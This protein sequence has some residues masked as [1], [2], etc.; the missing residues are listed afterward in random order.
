MFD[1]ID[2]HYLHLAIVEPPRTASAAADLQQAESFSEG[3]STATVVAH[4]TSANLA[5]NSAASPTWRTS[6]K[7]T[8]IVTAV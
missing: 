6:S 5:T 8:L 2:L 4:I 7:R 3:I 1:R